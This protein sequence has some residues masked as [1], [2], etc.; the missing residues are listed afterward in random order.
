PVDI[1]HTVAGSERYWISHASDNRKAILKHRRNLIDEKYMASLFPEAAYVAQ[2]VAD[3]P[4]YWYNPTYDASWL[5]Q[6]MTFGMEAV[7]SFRGLYQVYEMNYDTES[8][9]VPVL[10]V[11]GRYDYAVPHTLWKNALSRLQHVTF[12]VLDRSGH[13]PQLEQPNAFDKILLEWLHRQ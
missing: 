10:I 1:A 8:P 11:M 4:L 9:K 5:W 7:H 3:A 2:Y 6:G 13:T 12:K